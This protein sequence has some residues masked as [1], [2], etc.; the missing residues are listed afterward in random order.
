MLARLRFGRNCSALPPTRPSIWMGAYKTSTRVDPIAWWLH[1][2]NWIQP[3]GVS[4]AAFHSSGGDS[5]HE[6]SA[7]HSGIVSVISL[8]LRICPLL[9]IAILCTVP[10]HLGKLPGLVFLFQSVGKFV[11]SVWQCPSRHNVLWN[12]FTFSL[13]TGTVF[14]NKVRPATEKCA[15]L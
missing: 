7:P 13:G 14:S 1:V 2:P 12:P 15:P 5:H 8:Q 3:C 10:K 6:S 4:G 11:L 9:L